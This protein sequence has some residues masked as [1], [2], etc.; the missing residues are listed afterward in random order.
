MNDFS[1]SF[2]PVRRHAEP[3]STGY[4]IFLIFDV[5]LLLWTNTILNDSTNF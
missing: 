5:M 2:Q 3:V 1:D 4:E